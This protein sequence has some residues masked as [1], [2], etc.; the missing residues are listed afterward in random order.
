V[1]RAC[2]KHG[3]KLVVVDYLQK[4]HPAQ[5]HEKQ[6]YEVGEVSGALKALACKPVPRS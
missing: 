3:I 4:I 6:T 2:R 1:R 5:Q